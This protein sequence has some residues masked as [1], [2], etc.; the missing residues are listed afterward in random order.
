MRLRTNTAS[1]LAGLAVLAIVFGGCIAPQTVDP[2]I[3]VIEKVRLADDVLVSVGPRRIL[4]S[5][6]K[7]I[8]KHDRDIAIVDGL[9][10]RDT[11]FPEGEWRLSALVEVPE[12]RSSVAAALDVKYLVLVGPA[13]LEEITDEK[14]EFYGIVPSA[15]SGTETS[16]LS[17]VVID[18]NSGQSL[19]QI[20]AKASGTYRVGAYLIY[21]AGTDP[22]TESAVYSGLSEA[23]VGAVRK[24]SGEGKVRLALLAAEGTAEP[25]RSLD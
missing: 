24:D 17:A 1:P 16:T 21:V 7:R 4:E 11:A 20:V 25:F 18:L 15:V 6:S 22:M 8:A 2:E 10:F 5:L 23:I 14:G 12:R 13:K 3:H 19:S 9:T